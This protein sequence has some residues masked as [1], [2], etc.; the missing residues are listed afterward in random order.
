MF[1]RA[2]RVMTLGG[3]DVRFDPSLVLLVALLL[4]VLNERLALR[5]SLP[6]ALLLAVVTSVL[7]LASVLAHE[8]GHALEAR[9]RGLGVGSITLFA[10]G[11]ATEITG[12]GRTPREEFAVS[13]AGPWVSIVIAATAGL[14]ATGAERL[15]AGDIAAAVG[16]VAGLVGWLN[17]G[18][19]AF[20]L[21]PAAPLDGGRVL[22]ALLWRGMRDRH[23]ATS[24]TSTLGVV[25][26]AALV[27][28]GIRSALTAGTPIPGLATLA[29]GVFVI[30]SAE[31]ERRRDRRART[32]TD[33]TPEPDV[34]GW[35]GPRPVGVGRS[36]MVSASVA[37]VTI[38][39]LGIPMPFVEYRPG[40]AVAIEPLVLIDGADVTPLEGE[41]ALLTVR[42]TRPTPVQLVAAALDR[43]RELLTLTRVYPQGVDR[44]VHLAR[45]RERFD[46]QFDVAAA[47]GAAA[48][49]VPL[50][51]LTAVVV[52]T[53]DPA[54]AAADQLAPGD[55]IL[56]ID[57]EPL[58]SGA[59]LSERVRNTPAGVPLTLRVQ[60]AG[61]EQDRI[62]TPVT[63]SD[64]ATPRIGVTVQT[65]V[66][67]LVLP[68]DITLTPGVRI[69]GSSAGLMV[70]LTVYDLLADEDLL[71]GRKV[72]GTGTLDVDGMVGPVGGVPEK[73]I[74]AMNA[75]Y[76]VVLVPEAET[77]LAERVAAGRITVIGVA[78]LVEAIEGLRRSS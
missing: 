47:V 66:D 52:I 18:L 49:G 75:G 73:T 58:T 45:E 72:A 1:R 31:G 25:L 14:V 26:G 35:S 63:T 39:A 60:H 54:G 53:V 13:F 71:R 61:I 50:E 15:P 33:G 4:W 20:N 28:V 34:L 67:R 44:Q 76:D 69:G 57:G 78:S 16:L 30:V 21:L 64:S 65:A 70:G 17:L 9:H 42:L 37:I 48:A 36:S 32:T 7:L 55:V 51:V 3:V 2:A 12:H 46:R 38:G 43:D 68:I 62:V 40:G 19:A 10:L 77:A 59:A 5:F 23:R 11:G 22:H 24:V 27:L 74:A 29:V 8:L 41:T 6:V 56:A